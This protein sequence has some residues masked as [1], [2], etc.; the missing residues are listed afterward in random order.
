MYKFIP[1]LAIS[2]GLHISRHHLEL[3]LQKFQDNQY[4][5]TENAVMNGDVY[6]KKLCLRK[7]GTP[8]ELD[9]ADL[10][11]SCEIKAHRKK[12]GEAFNDCFCR[13]GFIESA[14]NGECIPESECDEEY[15]PPCGENEEYGLYIDNEPHCTGSIDIGTFKDD[16]DVFDDFMKNVFGF[17]DESFGDD[18]AVTLKSAG[19][20]DGGFGG[21]EMDWL[22]VF[23][24]FGGGGSS[25]FDDIC[26]E[27]NSPIRKH[28]KYT[29]NYDGMKS[30][31]NTVSLNTKIV[32][33]QSHIYSPQAINNMK[34]MRGCHCKQ[35][36][37]RQKPSTQKY[38]WDVNGMPNKNKCIKVEDCGL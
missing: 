28:C 13:E 31:F 37:G 24:V 6:P 22:P 17:E 33:K 21:I 18:S 25:V 8:P 29:F 10:L 38:W 19:L 5:R 27:P 3:K 7:T 15:I 36:C 14:V 32:M 2:E 12:P 35:D 11:A 9:D 26:N 20:G 30:V 4:C 34:I 1:F 23:S 16:P